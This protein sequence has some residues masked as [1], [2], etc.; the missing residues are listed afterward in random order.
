M[1]AGRFVVVEKI[2]AGGMGVVYRA[3]DPELERIV[4]LEVLDRVLRSDATRIQKEA[5]ALA[6]LNHPNVVAVYEIGRD[7]AETF[8]AM[9]HVDGGS[10]ADWCERHPRGDATRTRRLVDMLRQAAQGLAAA[11]RTGFEDLDRLHEALR[12]RRAALASE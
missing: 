12:D 1:T 4:A 11:H 8:L 9:E 10:L 3:F 7:G 6:R 5:R 2:G